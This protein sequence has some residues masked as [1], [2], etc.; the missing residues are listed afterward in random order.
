MSEV[1]RLVDELTRAVEGDAWHGD[2]IA[3]ILDGV[4]AATA[5][6]KPDPRTHS[7]WEIARHM[8]AWTG[9]VARR[10]AGHPAGEPQEGDWPAPTGRGD[11]DWRR[12]VAAFFDAHRRLIAIVE[13]F[14]DAALFEPINDPRDRATGTGVTRDV[15][16]HGLA[17][18]HAYHGGQIALLKK[19]LIA[20]PHTD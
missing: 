16:L 8:T 18:H 4:S 19:L 6:A 9:E 14:S 3:A 12:D 15:L 7:I 1:S 5:A 13:S 2:S 17:Q 11:A 10:F 20:P